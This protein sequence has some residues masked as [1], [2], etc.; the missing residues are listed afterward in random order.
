VL[1]ALTAL[2]A[3]A[4]VAGT[5]TA[6]AHA[7]GSPASDEPG[8]NVAL[9]DSRFPDAQGDLT[10]PTRDTTG[11]SPTPSAVPT[12]AAPTTTTTTT[13]TPPPPPPETSEPAP[14]PEPSPAAPDLSQQD[15]VVSIVNS[16]RGQAGCGPLAIDARL[17]AAA[18][19]HSSDM[20]NRD[21]FSHDTPEGVTFDKRI[22]NAGYTSP[23]AENIAM[24]AD[25]AE[26]VMRMW[27]ESP[28]HR[29]NILNCDLDT[30]GVGLDRNGYYW[31]QD[32]GY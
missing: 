32:F 10:R 15:Q 17:T 9:T 6:F 3:G 30:I 18:Q 29:A 8:L 1:P 7:S 22:R 12:S 23:A 26:D 31:T 25:N 5:V 19:A 20:A 24:G 4:I 28:G 14:P 16:A 21:Y 2:F 13:T 27:M 11:G